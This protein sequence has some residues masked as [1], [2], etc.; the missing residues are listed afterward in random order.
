MRANEQVFKNSFP[1]RIRFKVQTERLDE[2]IS[3]TEIIDNTK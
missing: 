3:D 2:T 1:T